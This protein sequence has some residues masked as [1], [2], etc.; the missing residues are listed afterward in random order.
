MASA[1]WLHSRVDP[2]EALSLQLTP[3]EGAGAFAG[4]RCLRFEFTSRGDRVPGRLYLPGSSAPGSQKLPWVLLQHGLA[5]SMQSDYL[6][7]A[8]RWIAEGAGVAMIDLPLH[9]ERSS[10]KLSERLF[11]TAI[12]PD[13]RIDTESRTLLHEFARQSVIDLRRACDAIAT[14][15]ELDPERFA[16]AGFS[17]GAI[18]GV[19]FCAQD[20][21]PRAAVLALAGAGLGPTSSTPRPS[22]ARSRRARWS[23]SMPRATSACRPRAPRSCSKPEPSPSSS[24]GSRPITASCPAKR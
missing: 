14:V 16:F 24:T 19:A 1:P 11:E 3:S 6:E 12:L 5:G 4:A 17:L 13:D 10:P 15:P 20:P 2:D 23:W 21:R 8:A 7:V 18:L 22:R 9:G